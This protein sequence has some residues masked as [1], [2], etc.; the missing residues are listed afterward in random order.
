MNVLQRAASPLWCHSFGNFDYFAVIC[1]Y[2]IKQHTKRH[3][4]YM[5]N[6]GLH[7]P[8]GFE[9]TASKGVLG[10]ANSGRFR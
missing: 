4:N 1:S 8:S 9:N 7:T 2:V 6:D 3:S 10:K 5:I